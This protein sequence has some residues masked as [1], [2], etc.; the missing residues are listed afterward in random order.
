MN[1]A[2][3]AAHSPRDGDA[4]SDAHP[5]RDHLQSVAALARQAAT[6]FGAEEWAEL[7]GL[8]HDLGKYRTSFQQY[9]RGTYAGDKSHQFAGAAWAM[10]VLSER[11]GA[12]PIA[13]AIA[14]H[15]GG[16]RAWTVEENVEEKT[17]EERRKGQ[18][19]N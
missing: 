8:W 14:G 10:N 9:I 3:P 18:A 7:A 19:F 11:E 6:A 13:L 16:L 12:L 5:L 1:P 15:H 2:D 17:V 4:W